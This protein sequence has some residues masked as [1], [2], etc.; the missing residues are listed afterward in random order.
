VTEHEGLV[1]FFFFKEVLP[2]FVGLQG[3]NCDK[4]QGLN[5]LG[6]QALSKWLTSSMVIFDGRI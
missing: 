2:L 6:Q 3:Q 5:L 4:S 1:V